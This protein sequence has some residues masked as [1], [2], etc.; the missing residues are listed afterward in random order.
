LIAA[1]V[2]FWAAWFLMPEPGTVD[3]SYILGAVSENRGRVLLSAILQTVCAVALVP[4]ALGA[5]EARSKL[6]SVGACLLLIG[7]LGN[8][9]DA[10]YHQMAYEMTAP[11]VDR[12]AMLPVMT[13]M[14]TEQ[15]L[16]L[17]PI[18]VSFFPGAVC[19]S[20][21]LARAGLAPRRVWLLYAAALVVGLAGMVLATTAGM[22]PRPFSLTSLGLVS[23]ALA[24]TGFGMRRAPAI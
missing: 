18:L 8:A 24:A 6:A 20:L 5:V 21:G 3:A 10:V 2:L 19:L 22:S 4:A 13:R 14:Q 12:D 17:A 11:D 23:A 16:L 9:A 7:A 15:I 1:S